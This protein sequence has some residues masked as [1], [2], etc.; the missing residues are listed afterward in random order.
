MPQG[1]IDE[2]EDVRQAA[3]RELREEI[4]MD[5]AEI[6]AESNGWFRYELPQELA[7]KAWNGKWR[8]QRQKWFVMRF[9]GRD[10]D[11]NLD[12]EHP[13]FRAWKWVPVNELPAMVVSFKRQ[14]YVD[15]L[16]EFPEFARAPN[17]RIV[18]F[19]DDPL[20]RVVMAADG[21]EEHELYNLLQRAARKLE[22]RDS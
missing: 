9:R 16:A 1:G 5:K 10:A 7:G 14:V 12:T 6:V 8:G 21:V 15:L 19:L 20:I 17:R 22:S 13:E 4:G 3:Y 2:G 11:I 18:D